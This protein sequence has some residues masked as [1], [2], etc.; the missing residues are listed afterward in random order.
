MKR[1]FTLLTFCCFVSATFAQS[2]GQ[3]VYSILQA[4]C[5]TSGCHSSNDQIAGLDLQGNGIAQVRAN[6]FNIDPE[7]ATANQK[8]H[9]L[10]Y[11]G[12]PYKSFLFRKINDGLA[13]SDVLDAD[14]GESMPPANSPQLTDYEKEIIRQWINFGA[15]LNGQVV[16]P[17]LLQE[18]YGPDGNL[19]AD[20]NGIWSIDPQNP[21]APP[22]EGFQ[23]H[24]G[25]FFLPPSS[26]DDRA[27]TEFYSKW[28]ANNDLPFEVTRINTIMGSSH[29][30]IG[31]YCED[32]CDNVDYGY[33]E[34]A[35]FL[36]RQWTAVQEPKD[37][38]LPLGTA[39]SFPANSVLD[40][41]S[42][43]INFSFTAPLACEVY[44]N[45]HT[46][47]EGIAVQEMFNELLIDFN[48]FIPNNGDTIVRESAFFDNNAPT[49]HV[50]QLG[51]HTHEKGVDFDVWLRNEDGSKGEQLLDASK[52]RGLPECN[53]V[54]YDYAHPPSVEYSP[55]LPIDMSQGIIHRA[56]WVNNSDQSTFFG[57]LSTDEMMITTVSY[58][59]GVEGVTPGEASVCVDPEPPVGIE[60]EFISDK[61]M[62]I[63]PNPF[64][65]HATVQLNDNLIQG[66]YQIEVID[67]LGKK[68]QSHSIDHTS[69]NT[70]LS[71]SRNELQ[72]G[73]YFIKLLQSGETLSI[74]KVIVR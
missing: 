29:H 9:K 30:F 22:E 48:F 39:Y 47:E 13:A 36:A 70:F 37:I 7:N 52:F 68:H 2:T 33:R 71:I 34:D 64:S 54:V 20:D 56:K 10:I 23:I 65:Q 15:V 27:E 66:S 72:N 63:Y 58:T 18:F 43:Y 53:D 69:N 4:K 73:V 74:Q 16:N 59:L 42:H 51:S 45:V 46:Q 5:A 38:Q 8:Q 21:P 24:M 31:Y 6:L 50:W 26:F 28:D 35:N 44:V 61:Q 41:N 55:F 67:L 19:S 32:D 49:I 14:E 1:I 25:P 3:E 40:L 60:D 12:D 11:P 57:V 17:Q 62:L